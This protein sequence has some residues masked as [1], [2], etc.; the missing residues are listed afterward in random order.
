MI[1]TIG[2]VMTMMMML[3]TM[4]TADSRVGRQP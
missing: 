1:L 2:D 3:L 4:L